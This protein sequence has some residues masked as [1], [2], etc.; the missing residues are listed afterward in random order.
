MLGGEIL[1][2]RYERTQSRL[3]EIVQAGFTVVTEWEGTWDRAKITEQ[4]TE[5]LT[6][7]IE[8]RSPLRKRDALYGGRRGRVC[9][10]R[11]AMTRPSN[12]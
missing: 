7:P 4:K 8:S 1:A 10:T 12:M 9:T 3:K 6:H 11:R 2:Q 5:L